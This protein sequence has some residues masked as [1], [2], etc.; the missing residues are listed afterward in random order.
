MSAS[1]SVKFGAWLLI[2]LNLLM[3]FGSIWVFMR[4][5]PAIETIIARNA[6]SFE[7]TEDMLAALL[8]P[9]EK[10]SNTQ[11]SQVMFEH[12][13]ERARNN[14]TEDK[15]PFYVTQITANYKKAFAG[16]IEAKMLTVKGITALGNINSI[17]MRVADAKAQQLG[18]SGAWGVVFMAST[19]FALGL[20]FLRFL[21]KTLMEPIQEIEATLKAFRQGEWMRR[22]SLKDAPPSMHNV[23]TAINEVLDSL[24]ARIASDSPYIPG[25]SAHEKRKET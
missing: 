23:F 7:A 11:A 4:M 14:I 2:A 25:P 8:A 18:R 17:A 24:C 10:L 16:D 6:V 3:A 12:A 22:C 5:S 9:E 21:D 15:E 13:L 1:K 20:L 19:S